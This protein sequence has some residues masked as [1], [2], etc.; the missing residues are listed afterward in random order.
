MDEED[1]YL[2]SE[3]Y[4]PEDLE[5]SDVDTKTGISESQED[6]DDFYMNKQKSANTNKKT[7]TDILL[8]A[9]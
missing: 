2:S 5:A 6:I 3:F 1:E 4:Y 7:A 9:T 8:S